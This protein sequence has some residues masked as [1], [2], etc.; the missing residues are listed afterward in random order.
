MYSSFCN[1]TLQNIISKPFVILNLIFVGI[2]KFLIF[3]KNSFSSDLILNSRFEILIN[4]FFKLVENSFGIT[5]SD[6]FSF[7]SGYVTKDIGFSN[8]S[9]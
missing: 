4:F 7:K 9:G 5:G 2:S 8:I 6:I 1:F 3:L